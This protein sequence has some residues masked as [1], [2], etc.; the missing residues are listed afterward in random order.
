MAVTTINP[1]LPQNADLLNNDQAAAYIGVTPR[2]LEVWRCTKRHPISFIKVGRL[3]K[4]RKSALD[5][6]LDQQ[7]VEAK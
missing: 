1:I 6:F 2:T 4:Y 7:T 3:V 5:A